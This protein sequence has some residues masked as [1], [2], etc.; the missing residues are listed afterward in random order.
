MSEFIVA[1]KHP[2]FREEREWR[3]VYVEETR[4]PYDDAAELPLFRAVGGNV[5]PYVITSFKEAVEFSKDD[6]NGLAFPI[7]D[8]MIGPTID[9]KLNT[10]SV[11]LL[12]LSLN[13]HIVP[14]VRSSDIPLRWL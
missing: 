11:T 5:V 1:F 2:E 9:P 6:T 10:R 12:L 8:V 14:N 4:P 13:R 3:L 7:V